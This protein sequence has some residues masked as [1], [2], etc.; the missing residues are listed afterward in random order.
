VWQMRPVSVEASIRCDM[1]GDGGS[2]W[3]LFV[4]LN[5]IL[6]S[7]SYFPLFS[8]FF[9]QLLRRPTHRETRFQRAKGFRRLMTGSRWWER[10]R[11][12]MMFSQP[13]TLLT[14]IHNQLSKKFHFR[15]LCW[16][17]VSKALTFVFLSPLWY[18]NCSSKV[19]PS[20][21]CFLNVLCRFEW[22]A[23][24][25]FWWWLGFSGDLI[26]GIFNQSRY[27]KLQ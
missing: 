2:S 23:Q 9:I 24:G 22:S 26:E 6:V 10:D 25:G 17:F 21:F 3:S 11:S 19:S 12:G 7:I 14:Q 1:D 18:E 27:L 4:S 15:I 13:G 5:V 16:C 20:H 8:H